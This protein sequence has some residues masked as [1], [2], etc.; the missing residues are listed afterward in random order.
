ME[1]V[2]TVRCMM[3][4]AGAHMFYIVRFTVTS[5]TFHLFVNYVL[6]IVKQV[7]WQARDLYTH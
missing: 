4:G 3:Y 1:C 2:A 7:A 6:F 5:N